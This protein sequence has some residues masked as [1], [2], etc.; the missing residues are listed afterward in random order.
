MRIPSA[1]L[2]LCSKNC[3]FTLILTSTECEKIIVILSLHPYRKAPNV[4][5]RTTTYTYNPAQENELRQL[6]D[7]QLIPFLHQLPGFVSYT[8]G[9]DAATRRGIS[10]TV[11][12]SQEAAD[13]FRT[14]MGGMVQSF[15]AV[16]LQIDP[17]QVYEMI[18]QIP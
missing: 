1:S 6:N 5:I 12:E 17:S 3:H 4:Y 14:A 18:R 2:P 8:Y 7:G 15:Q 16:G 9:L 10:I 13:G 11:W